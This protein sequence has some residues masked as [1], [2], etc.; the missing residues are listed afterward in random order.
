MTSV[1]TSNLDF[2]EWDQAFAKN[3]LLATATLDRLLHNPYRLTLQGNSYRK[4]RD[5]KKPKVAKG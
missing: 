4:P 3:K 1:M 2:T 5:T